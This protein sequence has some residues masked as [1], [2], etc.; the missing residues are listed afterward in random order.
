M[1]IV[2][3]ILSA[4][5]MLSG[6]PEMG[7]EGV[8]MTKSR[9]IRIE[10]NQIASETQTI[11]PVD[12]WR[13]EDI[14]EDNPVAEK[15]ARARYNASE[16]EIDCL[17]SA[18]Y[19]EARGEPL[20][21]RVAIV[22]VILARRDSG[23]WPKNACGVISQ[24]SQFSFVNGGHIPKIA[25]KDRQGFRTLVMRVLSGE[26]SSPARGATY[27]HASHARPSWRHEMRRVSQIGRH[28]FYKS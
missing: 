10:A 19:H 28:F 16:R 23:K 7:E 22:E 5:M 21:G 12:Q 9:A 20:Q 18:V 6:T 4:F 11:P 3:A 26:L 2:Y 1:D 14:P 8:E 15:P 17:V 27:F 24:K 13:E 25:G